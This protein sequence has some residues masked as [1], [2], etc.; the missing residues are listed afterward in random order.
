MANESTIPGV[1]SGQLP[2]GIFD[3]G[4]KFEPKQEFIDAAR[5]KAL[6]EGKKYN[7]INNPARDLVRLL[8]PHYDKIVA[9]LSG[10]KQNLDMIW[11]DD[12]EE[13]IEE[14]WHRIHDANYVI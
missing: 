5:A 14:V 13:I 11:H 12:L 10:G 4:G 1:P 9:D 3:E 7:I 6:E 8:E 2:T